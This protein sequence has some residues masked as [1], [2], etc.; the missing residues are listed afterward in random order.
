MSTPSLAPRLAALG[1]SLLLLAS[2]C[3]RD[4]VPTA[5]AESSE[6]DSSE[7]SS[8]EPDPDPTETGPDPSTEEEASEEESGETEEPDLLGCDELVDCLTGCIMD[9]GLDCLAECGTNADPQELDEAAAL[10]AC[11]G[12]QCVEKG[13]CDFANDFDQ[14]SC[15]G[16][17]GLGLFLPEPPGCEAEA[18]I[19]NGEEPPPDP[20]TGDGDGDPTTGDGDGD[21]TTGDGD[22]EGTTGEPTTGDGDGDGSTGEPTTGDGDGDTN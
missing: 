16:C 11:I 7:A 20:T 18:A 3:A 9:L 22:G 14:V 10:L 19:C 13:E 4:E 15:L 17:I 1:A 8:G 2:A 6:S 21:L 12:G 5:E